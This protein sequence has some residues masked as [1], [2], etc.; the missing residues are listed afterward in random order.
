MTFYTVSSLPCPPWRDMPVKYCNCYVIYK[1]W[2][3]N[4][5]PI[6]SGQIWARGAT[7]MYYAD[8]VRIFITESYCDKSCKPGLGQGFQSFD[9]EALDGF[10]VSFI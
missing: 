6:V 4:L 10:Q 1:P 9:L 3:Y 5:I 8:A 2:Q 7:Y